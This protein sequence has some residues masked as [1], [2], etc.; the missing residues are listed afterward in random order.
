M[1]DDSVCQQVMIADS[2]EIEIEAEPEAEP[3]PAD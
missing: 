2:G 1:T 3:S